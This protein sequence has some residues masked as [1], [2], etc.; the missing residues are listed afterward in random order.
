[1]EAGS[2][3]EEGP[4]QAKMRLEWATRHRRIMVAVQ[5]VSMVGGTIF[6]VFVD[7]LTGR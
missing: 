6:F 4:T 1:M 7:R 3:R 2:D 5:A